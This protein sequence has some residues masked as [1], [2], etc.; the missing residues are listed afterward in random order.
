MRSKERIEEIVT[1]AQAHLV[2]ADNAPRDGTQKDFKLFWEY[3]RAD[4]RE[5]LGCIDDFTTELN[6]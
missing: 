1:T 4:V 2:K 3:Y 6:Q 5:L